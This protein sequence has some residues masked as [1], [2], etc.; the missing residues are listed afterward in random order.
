MSAPASDFVVFLV[1][2]LFS[3]WILHIPSNY[4]YQSQKFRHSKPAGLAISAAITAKRNVIAESV[5]ALLSAATANSKR[6][7]ESAAALPS[8]STAGRKYN[9]KNAAAL[10]SVSIVKGKNSVKNAAATASASNSQNMQDT[11]AQ[12]IINLRSKLP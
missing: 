9:V 10:L 1:V 12:Q 7:A 4:P 3:Q 8:A 6:N 5:E 2:S 11:L